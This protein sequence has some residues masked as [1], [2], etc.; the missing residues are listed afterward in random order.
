[1][2]AKPLQC[3]S[4]IYNC[5]I[6][7]LTIG[8]TFAH[9]FRSMFATSCERRRMRWHVAQHIS[10]I[11]PTIYWDAGN[12]IVGNIVEVLNGLAGLQWR[13]PPSKAGTLEA[14]ANP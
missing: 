4:A 2:T 10:E 8:N 7:T 11:A 13:A 5:L 6:G 1:L 14:C 12:N 3:E 9:I